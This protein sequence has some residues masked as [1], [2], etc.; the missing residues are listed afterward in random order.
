MIVSYS[1]IAIATANPA[2]APAVPLD[3][4]VS[5]PCASTVIEERV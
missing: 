2:E 1:A 4:E 3:A 5:L